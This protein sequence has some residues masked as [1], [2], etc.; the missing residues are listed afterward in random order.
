MI[1]VIR[2]LFDLGRIKISEHWRCEQKDDCLIIGPKTG[3]TVLALVVFG[4]LGLYFAAAAF[5]IPE[6]SWPG[7]TLRDRL[8]LML[9]G[10]GVASLGPSF[11]YWGNGE[12]RLN[13]LGVEFHYFYRRRARLVILQWKDVERLRMLWNGWDLRGQDRKIFVPFQYLSAKHRLQVDA[14]LREILSP[15]FDLTTKPSPGGKFFQFVV[16][17][18]I[19]L[20]ALMT[21]GIVAIRLYLA[22]TAL[23]LIV[24]P[25]V[26]RWLMGIWLLDLIGLCIAQVIILHK[27]GN[28]NNPWRF[29]REHQATMIH[30]YEI[31]KN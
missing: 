10:V 14:F 30:E 3:Q 28:K 22:H 23:H 25:I 20:F 26:V 24:Q 27:Q 4:I 11:A 29:R 16:A 12:W 13:P 9:L 6:H 7:M 18:Q 1:P 19:G 31:L 5:I 17:P 2:K 8:G 15:H 21:G